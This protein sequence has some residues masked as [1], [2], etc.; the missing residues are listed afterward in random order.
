MSAVLSL[1]LLLWSWPLLA[2]ADEAPKVL[3]LGDSLSAAYGLPL[4]QGWVSLLQQ[5]L[6][7]HHLPHRVINA[8]I[9]G[10]TTS[11]GLARLPELLRAHRP[12]VLILQLGAND[13]LRGI[14]LGE[15]DGNLE[16]LIAL[17]QAAG[18]RVLMLG[19]R[20]PPNYGPVY[21]EGF[22][23]TLA[24]VAARTGAGFVPQWLAGVDEE[25][26]LMQP[27]GLHPTAAA[28]PRLL[29]NVWPALEPLLQ[30]APGAQ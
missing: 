8:S 3:I 10:E 12:A 6:A 4:E 11:G 19:V 25:R 14:H 26:A 5:R 28:Q 15:L 22:A 20:L 23:R 9:S 27:D 17:A 16:R 29:D 7:A 18:S 13:G 2:S 30:D 21:S 1:L 24:E